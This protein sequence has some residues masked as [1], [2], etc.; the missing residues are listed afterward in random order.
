MLVVVLPDFGVPLV[1]W[2]P[3]AWRDLKGVTGLTLFG[4]TVSGVI[5]GTLI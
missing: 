2:P 1:E 3:P 4:F 5:L